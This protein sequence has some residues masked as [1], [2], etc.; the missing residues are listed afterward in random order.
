MGDTCKRCVA[1]LRYTVHTLML[2]EPAYRTVCRMGRVIPK[3][4]EALEEGLYADGFLHVRDLLCA[5]LAHA[6]AGHELFD[7]GEL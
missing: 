1:H 4:R 2:S 3:H 7:A 6:C 5:D